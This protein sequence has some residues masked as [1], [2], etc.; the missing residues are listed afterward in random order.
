MSAEGAERADRHE[1]VGVHEA[2]DCRQLAALQSESNQPFNGWLFFLRLDADFTQDFLD[3]NHFWNVSNGRGNRILL[4]NRLG[5]M[6]DLSAQFGE[7]RCDMNVTEQD[8]SCS[9]ANLMAGWADNKIHSVPI[10]DHGL[11]R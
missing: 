11:Q 4:S 3:G 10:L 7:S 8:G 5:S 1:I 9:Q 6:R 2:I